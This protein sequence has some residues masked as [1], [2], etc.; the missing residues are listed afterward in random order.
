MWQTQLLLFFLFF[1][2]FSGESFE[3]FPKKTNKPCE[4]V[5]AHFATDEITHNKIWLCEKGWGGTG[6]KTGEPTGA[7]QQHGKDVVTRRLS[8]QR[9]RGGT[10]WQA[11]GGSDTVTGPVSRPP[12]RSAPQQSVPV[13]LCSA[14]FYSSTNCARA[15]AAQSQAMHIPMSS[16]VVTS[17]TSQP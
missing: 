8:R 1:S 16:P 9:R 2:Y 17:A 3:K 11:G 4:T 15:A 14:A 5:A 6:G 12:A 10:G 7:W 13:P